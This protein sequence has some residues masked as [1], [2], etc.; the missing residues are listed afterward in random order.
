MKKLLT[1]LMIMIALSITSTISAQRVIVEH[2]DYN[3]GDLTN[4]G[5][6]ENG[7]NGSWYRTDGYFRV[8]D[9]NVGVDYI[10]RHIETKLDETKETKLYRNLTDTFKVVDGA[11]YWISFYTKRLAASGDKWGGLS[12]ISGSNEDLFIGSR[13]QS[14]VLGFD[15]GDESAYTDVSDSD[16][17]YVL[18]KIEMRNDGT[19]Q[20][21]MWVNYFDAEEPIIATAQATGSYPKDGVSTSVGFSK[22]RVASCAGNAFSFDMITISDSYKNAY[23]SEEA[24]LSKITVNGLSIEGFDGDWFEY[25]AQLPA[26]T[27]NLPVIVATPKDPR[28]TVE[29]STVLALEGIITIQVTAFD[30][31]TMNTYHVNTSVASGLYDIADASVNSYPN[32]ATDLLTIT[33]TANSQVS[34][35]N[36]QG[37]IIKSSLANTS[38]I[39]MDVSDIEA[40]IYM[41]K[42]QSKQKT[43]SKMVSIVK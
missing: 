36:M 30:G 9:G 22:I 37:K 43:I 18:V 8:I 19:G 40:G 25:D 16:E 35:V 42:I 14:E 5:L 12:L 11:E 6:A 23:I 39:T 27:T 38:S 32:P 31:V 20:A 41:V 13:Y 4:K 17:N 26:G 24:R 7:W 2:F 28:A 34:I 15:S 10:G 33:N 21:Y 1:T 3:I 29:V